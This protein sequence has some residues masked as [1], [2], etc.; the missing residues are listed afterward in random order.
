VRSEVANGLAASRLRRAASRVYGEA[1]ST[2][3]RDFTNRE[4]RELFII[5][6]YRRQASPVE[7]EL[8]GDLE[9]FVSDVLSVIRRRTRV[10]KKLHAAPSAV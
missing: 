8:D 9:S 5:D 3:P 7:V 1:H 6:V 10:P 4:L 2:D